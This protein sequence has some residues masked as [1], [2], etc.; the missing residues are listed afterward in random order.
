MNDYNTLQTLGKAIPEIDFAERF[1]TRVISDRR[2][3][4]AEI[5]SFKKR[6]FDRFCSRYFDG[7]QQK[8]ISAVMTLRITHFTQIIV[9][10]DISTRSQKILN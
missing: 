2:V 4:Y 5:D 9:E 1:S 10:Y 6:I 3:A 7:V 8:I